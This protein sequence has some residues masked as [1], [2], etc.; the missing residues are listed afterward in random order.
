[1]KKKIL[2]LIAAA[3]VCASFTGC[4]GDNGSGSAAV[5]AETSP[6]SRTAALK[7]AVTLPEMIEVKAEQ[8]GDRYGIDGADVTGFS[9]FVCGSGAMPDEFGVFNAKDADA[10]KRVSE[11]LTK[12]IE[13]QTKTYK[14]YTPAEAYKLED[15]FVETNGTTVSYAICADNSKA[16]ELLTH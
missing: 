4:G 10:A 15:S 3:V 16:R 13:N 14:D 11:A 9:A 1:M 6:Q 7:E 5:S 12:R 2:A 8:L